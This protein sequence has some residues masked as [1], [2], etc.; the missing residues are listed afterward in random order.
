MRGKT[1]LIALALMLIIGSVAVLTGSMYALAEM[2]VEG[3]EYDRND[4]VDESMFVSVETPLSQSELQEKF[5]GMVE[6]VSNEEPAESTEEP[7]VRSTTVVTEA[8]L[9]EYWNGENAPQGI[10]S[11]SAEEVYFITN[12]SIRIYNEYDEIILP[13]YEL[14]ESIKEIADSFPAIN[15][16]TITPSEDLKTAATDIYDII[17]YRLIVLSS[18][19]CIVTRSEASEAKELYRKDDFGTIKEGFFYIM[20]YPED[21]DR[22]AM[23]EV[24]V[25]HSTATSPNVKFLSVHTWPNGSPNMLYSSNNTILDRI[26]ATEEMVQAFF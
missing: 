20:D 6:E 21:A 12:D 23:L 8:F 9:D 2:P 26:F 15:G 25:W 16:R 22:A 11:L 18:P 1:K 4:F 13:A 14:P 24:V 7:T 5:D 10:R 17:R 19:E 3:S